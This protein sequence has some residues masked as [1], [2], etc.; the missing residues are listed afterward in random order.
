MSK[1]KLINKNTDEETI[2]EK[3]TIDGFEYYV[4]DDVIPD[5][6]YYISLETDYATEPK[7]RFV[8]YVKSS[9]LNGHNPRL[10][11][12]TNNPNISIPNVV[13]EVERLAIENGNNYAHSYNPEIFIEGYKKSQETHPFTEEDFENLMEFIESFYFRRFENGKWKRI[14]NN[15][16]DFPKDFKSLTTKEFLQLWKEQ[17]VNTLYYE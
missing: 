8:L 16:E 10:V 15:P 14:T 3:V 1:Y 13:D 2:C 7:E 17:K 9:G 11:I 4:S 12:A 5:E 6:H